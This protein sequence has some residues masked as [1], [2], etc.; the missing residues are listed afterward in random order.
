MKR[1]S[2]VRAFIQVNYDLLSNNSLTRNSLLFLMLLQA[3]VILAYPFFIFTYSTSRFKSMMLVLYERN[4][5]NSYLAFQSVVLGSISLGLLEYLVY[6][7]SQWMQIRKRDRSLK[8]YEDEKEVLTTS[9][10]HLLNFMI[11]QFSFNSLVLAIPARTFAIRALIIVQSDNG[12]LSINQKTQMTVLAIMTL[13][14]EFAS[15]SLYHFCI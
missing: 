15:T 9:K 8:T 4:T 5:P 11:L 2:F 12:V 1:S 3:C 6:M 7:L 14:A 10:K 13:L